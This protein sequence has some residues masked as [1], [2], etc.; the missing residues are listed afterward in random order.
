M[1]SKNRTQKG[2][3]KLLIDGASKLVKE[4]KLKEAL[5]VLT[6]ALWHNPNDVHVRRARAFVY[7]KMG[8]YDSAIRELEAAI[9]LTPHCSRCFYERGQ[10]KMFSGRI[11]EAIED[12]ST[13]LRLEPNFAD[14]YSARAGLYAKTGHYLK[15]LKDITK[16][17]SIK[18]TNPDYLHN[19][20][21]VLAGLKWY[22]LAIRDYLKVIHLR[23]NSA[24]SYNNLA[25]IY[26]TAEDPAYRDCKK[27]I[28][29]AQRA[30][31]MG[32]NPAW[33]DTLA[34]AYAEC[35]NF[36]LAA[37]TEQEAYQLSSPP[38]PLFLKRAEIYKS[39][40]TYDKWLHNRLNKAEGRNEHV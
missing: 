32:R 23:P 7:A 24:G 38:N 3:I 37:Q 1:A 4:G 20:A 21:V 9:R 22:G 18:P 16:A 27:A 8:R 19:R 14:A 40:F 25:W 34:S 35:G 17:L 6:E 29:Y 36:E 15:A 13:C 39:R 26:A 33:M 2:T 31:E 28:R 10:A 11:Q 12:F 30:L 5:R